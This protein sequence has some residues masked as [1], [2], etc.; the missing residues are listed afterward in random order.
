MS[1]PTTV[2]KGQRIR[3][4]IEAGPVLMPGVF[5]ALSSR[6]AARAGFDVLFV[7]GYSVA[8]T[9][10]GLPDFGYLTGVEMAQIARPICDAAMGIPVIVDGDTGYGNP[11]NVQ[12]TVR[13]WIDAGAAGIFLEDQLW[14]KKCGHM[15]GKQ[16]IPIADQVQ[17]LRAAIDA[18]GDD[19]LFIVARTDAR[20]PLGLEAAIE[21]ALAFGETG[22][23]ATFIEAPQSREELEEIARRV[24]GIRVA[25][26]VEQG[27]TP[28]LTP[29]ELDEL[30]FRLIVH[31]ITALYAAAQGMRDALRV[32]HEKGTTRDDLG[33]LLRW[34]EFNDVIELDRFYALEE[35][36]GSDD[37]D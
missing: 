11:L 22:V 23:D 3:Q 7:S 24:P 17:K 20:A 4:A 32:L 19:D 6:L 1:D 28:M 5:D 13:D 37:G 2:S 16:V 31:P 34:D 10:L 21:R 33:G 26:M 15:A 25:N 27:K 9:R 35:R 36:Y 30:G 29:A 8:A 12:R 14:P 18:R